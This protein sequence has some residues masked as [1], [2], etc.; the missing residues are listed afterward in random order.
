MSLSSK[1][2]MLTGASMGIGEAIAHALA[3]EGARLILI[4]RSKDKLKKLIQTLSEKHPDFKGSFYATDVSDHQAVEETVSQAVKEAGQID[5]LI[6][7]AGLALGAPARFPDLSIADIVTMNNTNVNGYMFTTH[8]VLNQAM[9]PRGNGGTGTI[10]NITSTTALEAP[11]FPGEAVYHANKALQEAFTNALRNELSGTDIRVLALRPGVVAT[12]FHEQR[13]GF[14]RG[15]YDEFMKGFQPL[16][17]EDVASSAVFML[18]QP[19]NRSIKALDVVPSGVFS[20]PFSFLFMSPCR[21]KAARIARLTSAK[22]NDHSTFS[23]GNGMSETR[24]EASGPFDV[25]I[26]SQKP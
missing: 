6:N 3:A 2:V 8:A 13:V 12:H 11:P 16:L 22:R 18:S 25:C 14:D 10:L 24:S 5:I 4:S 15:M 7:N 1:V 23:T 17:A 26:I 20:F 19:L 21:P 9:L